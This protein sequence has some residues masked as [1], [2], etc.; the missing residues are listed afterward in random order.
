MKTAFWLRASPLA[1]L[2]LLLSLA[3]GLLSLAAC[4]DEPIYVC[5]DPYMPCLPD[6][7]ADAADAS[8]GH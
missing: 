4:D 3:A 8:S 6:A 7:G 5:P 2:P 1:L